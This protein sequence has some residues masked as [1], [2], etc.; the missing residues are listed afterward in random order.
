MMSVLYTVQRSKLWKTCGEYYGKVLQVIKFVYI[1]KYYKHTYIGNC[2]YVI[3]VQHL[4]IFLCRV[5][6]HLCYIIKV[7]MS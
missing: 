4:N 3:S 6:T 1:E 5:N 2:M 7:P